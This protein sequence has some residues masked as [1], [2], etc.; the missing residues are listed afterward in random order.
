M[1][2][3]EITG[4]IIDTGL[5]VHKQLGP[6]LFESVYESVLAWEL[7]EARLCVER[8]VPIPV[9]WKGKVIEEAFRADLVVEGR[10]I[11]EL[12]SVEKTAPVHRKQLITYLKLSGLKV[13]LLLNFGCALFN[14]GIVRIV[15]GAEEEGFYRGGKSSRAGISEIA[16]ETGKNESI[17]R[18][19]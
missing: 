6:G 12:K 9:V 13:G 16:E 11:V 18:N 7:T 3:N 5:S 2:D 14:E 17:L 8:Q 1:K 10:I 4:I 19:T 15:N